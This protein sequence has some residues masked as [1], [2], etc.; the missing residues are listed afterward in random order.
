MQMTKYLVIIAGAYKRLNLATELSLFPASHVPSA[1]LCC[2]WFCANPLL[3][4][5]V[6]PFDLNS[7]MVVAVEW[8]DHSLDGSP[9]K[10][11]LPFSAPQSYEWLSAV[12]SSTSDA[13]AFANVPFLT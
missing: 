3:G 8:A 10:V 13:S 7:S 11:L 9:L 12:P 6:S 1:S 4:T 5:Q 2:S